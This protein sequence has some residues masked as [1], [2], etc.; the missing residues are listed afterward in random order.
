MKRQKSRA[1]KDAEKIEELKKFIKKK[2]KEKDKLNVF[3]HT[4]LLVMSLKNVSINYN[5]NDGI[6]LPGYNLSLIHI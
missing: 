5:T 3:D 1:V 4:A 2:K 6:L